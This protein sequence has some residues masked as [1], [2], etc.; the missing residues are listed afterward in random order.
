MRVREN[1]RDSNVSIKVSERLNWEA[2]GE[3]DVFSPL[4]FFSGKPGNLRRILSL[5][6]RDYWIEESGHQFST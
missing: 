5:L 2:R 6:P 3:E 4:L 1:A